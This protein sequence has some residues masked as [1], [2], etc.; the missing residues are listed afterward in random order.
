MTP[1]DQAPKTIAVDGQEF[2]R[3]GGLVH[4][5]ELEE[6]H[7]FTSDQSHIQVTINYRHTVKGFK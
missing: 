7:Y 3:V 2:T 1:L 5:G 6:V 4:N